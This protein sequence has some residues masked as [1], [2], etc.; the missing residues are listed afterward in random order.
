MVAGTVVPIT[1]EGE[2]LDGTPFE[3]TDSVVLEARED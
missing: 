3:A 2:L 1:V